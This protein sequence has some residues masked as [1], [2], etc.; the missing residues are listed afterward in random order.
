MRRTTILFALLCLLAGLLAV[1]CYEPVDLRSSEDVDIPWVHCIL[2]PGSTQHLSLRYLSRPGE[3]NYRGINDASV[4]LSAWSREQYE[5]VGAFENTGDGEW[6]LQLESALF[7]VYSAASSPSYQLQIILPRGDTLTA[8]TTIA[9][10]KKHVSTHFVQCPTE[11]RAFVLHGKEVFRYIPEIT[12]YSLAS[13][14]PVW[15]CKEGWSEKAGNWSVFVEDEL[16]TNHEELA[17]SFN[18][19]GAL[20]NQSKVKAAL[21]FYPEVAGKPLHYRY[22]RFPRVSPQDTLAF[23]GD[24]T[25]PHFAGTYSGKLLSYPQDHSLEVMLDTISGQPHDLAE[26]D[27]LI[28]ERFGRM[29]FTA[30]SEEYDRYLLDVMQYEMLHVIGTDIVGVYDNTNIYTNI[31]GG[32][33]IFGSAVETTQ[34]WSCGV[35]GY[36]YEH[37]PE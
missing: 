1:A 4:V 3:D 35:V 26:C 22:I 18:L 20:F 19:T 6:T 5:P 15:V 36:V 12:Y 10:I 29:R 28:K 33:G 34:A 2:K 13:D 16:A 8:H 32:T 27:W 11:E 37:S 31:Q 7:D 24:F 14:Y 9:R 17:D 25:G 21:S 30:V 23:S